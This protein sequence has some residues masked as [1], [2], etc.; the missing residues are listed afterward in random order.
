MAVM[1]LAGQN[2]FLGSLLRV[3]AD[4]LALEMVQALVE[5]AGLGDAGIR[6]QIAPQHR[7]AASI[8]EGIVQ[9]VV[10]KARSGIE[11][12]VVTDIL[13]QRVGGDGHHIRF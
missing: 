12:L 9:R 4:S 11:V 3:K 5:S 13:R 2:G 10:D 1:D 8:A 6:R 7:H